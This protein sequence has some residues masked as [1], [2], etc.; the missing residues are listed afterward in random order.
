MDDLRDQA[1]HF[2]VFWSFRSPYSYL[3]TPQLIAV[4]AAYDVRIS[5]RPVRPLAMRDPSFF[6]RA[7][8]RWPLYAFNDVARLAQMQGLPFAPPRPDPIVQDM[9]TRRIASEQPYIGRITRLGQAAAELGAGL[10]FANAVAARIWGGIQDWHQE[11]SLPGAAAEAAIDWATI[12]Q[13]ERNNG[14][15]LNTAIAASEAAQN[16]SGHWGVPLMVFE[17]EPF[18][19]QDRIS[20]LIWRLGQRGLRPRRDAPHSQTDI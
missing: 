7:D 9:S 4:E 3:A 1:L 12:D 16:S 17:K 18:F 14:E 2:E 10:R 13:A 19:G 5:F 11:E 6:A 8:P 15:A 20:A